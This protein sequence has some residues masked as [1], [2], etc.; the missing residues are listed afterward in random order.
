MQRTDCT[1]PC[2]HEVIIR[3]HPIHQH[4]FHCKRGIRRNLLGASAAGGNLPGSCRSC[5]SRADHT[6]AGVGLPAQKPVRGLSPG[7]HSQFGTPGPSITLHICF[8]R[9]HHQGQHG[10]G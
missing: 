8:G 10:D 5:S 6:I 9:A 3:W 1:D 7:M 2:L 4:P